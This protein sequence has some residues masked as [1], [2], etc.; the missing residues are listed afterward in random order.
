MA[1]LFEAAGLST[2]LVTMM[3]YWAEKTGVPRTL[4]VEHPF[5]LTLGLPNDADQQQGVIRE[6][7]ALLESATEPG[8]IGHS[9]S[10]WPIPARQARKQWQPSEA[11]PIIAVI[12]PKLRQMLRE[13]RKKT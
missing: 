2:I 13:Q 12:A 7:L 10:Q 8:T 11:S 9:E 5:S 4:G 6:A 3:P 1:R